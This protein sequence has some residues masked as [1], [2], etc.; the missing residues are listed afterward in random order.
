MRFACW[1]L[2]SIENIQSELA[3]RLKKGVG[4]T[5]VS[6]C[7]WCA[8]IR[9]RPRRPGRLT[10]WRW[11]C[12]RTDMARM[13]DKINWPAA[14]LSA[15]VL[16]VL[17]LTG[18]HALMEWLSAVLGIEVMFLAFLLLLPIGMVYCGIIMIVM[19]LQILSGGR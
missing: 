14:Y 3:S 16:F 13:E 17:C 1:P 2:T 6:A 7:T 5:F 8:R 15:A 19:L 11:A 4:D 18:L 10:S 9:G 12:Y